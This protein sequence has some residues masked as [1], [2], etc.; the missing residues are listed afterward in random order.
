M[1]YLKQLQK[2][3]VVS[4]NFEAIGFYSYCTTEVV[5]VGNANNP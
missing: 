4:I 1:M 2:R 5:R 3:L